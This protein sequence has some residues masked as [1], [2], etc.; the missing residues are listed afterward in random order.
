MFVHRQ[1]KHGVTVLVAE[2]VSHHPPITAL[3]LANRT[4]G[5]HMNSYTAPE[6]RFW[7]NSLEV[8]LSGCIRITLDCHEGEEY[9]I[10]RPVVNMTGFLAGKQRLE[11]SGPADIVCERTGLTAHLEYKARGMMGR[12]EL[13]AISG[14][15]FESATNETLYTFDGYWDN[16]VT[17]TDVSTKE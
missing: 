15:I 12:G 5:F 4:L 9:R 16:I 6:P 14:R 8:R 11:F 10:T 7:G 2:Q 17:L 13:H 1:D 3:H